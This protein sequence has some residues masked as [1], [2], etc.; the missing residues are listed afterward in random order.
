MSTE[1]TAPTALV[2]VF[3][4]LKL[5][6]L[7]NGLRQS[8]GRTAAYVL[9]AVIGLLFTAAIVLGL[10]ALRGNPHAGTLAVTLTG[11]LTLGWAV[12]PLFFPTGDETLDPTR[13]VMLPL[14]PR[15]LIRAL[16]VTSLVGLGPLTTLV[17]ATGTVIAVA[18]GP[19]AAVVG[20][21]AVALV[22]LVC[23]ALARA[24]AT[25][26]V[27]LLTSRR[28]RDLAVL[29][30]L[31]VAFGAQ[32][33]NIAARQL[34]SPDGLSVLEPLGEVLRW[35]PPASAL[36]AVDDAGHG[37]YG[38]A[39]AGLALTVAALALLLWWWQR[40]LTALM[41]SPDSSTLQAVEKD[42]ARRSGGAERGLARLLPGGRT[43]TVM[44]RMLRYAWRDP[45]SKMSW[46]M[47]LGL[48][49]LLPVVYAA[50]GNGSIYTSF[51]ASA[52]LGLQ[53]YNQ[54]GQDTSA[55]WMVASTIATPRDAFVELRARALTLML[56]AVPY[57]TLVVVGA[58]A[59]IG[60]WSSFLEVYGLSLGLLGALVATG[61]MASALFPYSIPS[62][63]NK[64]V[65]PGQAGISW[66]SLFG[67]FLTAA[68]LTSP[69]LALTIGLHVAGLSGLL[70]VLL[71][72]GAV[73]GLGVATLGLR[74]A[75][76]RVAARLP[77]ILAAVSKG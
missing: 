14:R 39:A 20:V 69:L 44:L 6:L 18:D 57:V 59:F 42:S 72:A 52:L 1:A 27:R 77:E 73:Y 54:F 65:A 34:G 66:I 46:A 15:P 38:R 70:W 43:G 21:L 17:V 56:V 11:I 4:R 53:M 29:G 30:G 10:V 40:T 37:A 31:F 33:V 60:P 36:G 23:V 7:R 50:Q 76:P 47:A 45:K 16:L 2:P 5:T 48:G 64:N 74:L 3:V 49:L 25:A 28:G 35:V 13:L 67:G 62:D 51:S 71:P 9:S 55:F 24:V 68:A 41:T 61:A 75:A 58:A 26:S 22:V 63:G 8:T 19:A 12:M 32:G